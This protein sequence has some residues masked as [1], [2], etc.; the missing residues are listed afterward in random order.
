MLGQLARRAD[1]AC[2]HDQTAV[3]GV[4]GIVADSGTVTSGRDSAAD[5]A[6]A[7]DNIV[8]QLAEQH[9]VIGTASNI[10]VAKGTDANKSVID[11]ETMI[12]VVIDLVLG[13]P[14]GTVR[15][16][17]IARDRITFAVE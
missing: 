1:V 12:L 14:A 8:A 9:I 10:V 7:L 15:I 13:P 3:V 17:V 4:V 16:A 5:G 2:W 6:V 11:I